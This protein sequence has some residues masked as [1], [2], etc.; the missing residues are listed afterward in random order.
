MTFEQVLPILK[1][2]FGIKRKIWHNLHHYRICD[3]TL[4]YYSVNIDSITREDSF[5]KLNDLIADDWTFCSDYTE[6]LGDF[7]QNNKN[8]TFAN[9]DYKKLISAYQDGYYAGLGNGLNKGIKAGYESVSE[10]MKYYNLL[11]DKKQE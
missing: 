4:Y 2:G 11:I 5:I 10:I 9:D 7:E 8:K 1:Q 6:F 3:N